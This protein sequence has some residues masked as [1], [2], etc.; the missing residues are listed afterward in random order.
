MNELTHSNDVFFIHSDTQQFA[1]HTFNTPNFMR[2]GDPR[3]VKHTKAWL[4]FSL[5][6]TS[7]ISGEGEKDRI[8]L[9][10]VIHQ[11]FEKAKRE[12]EG[13]LAVKYD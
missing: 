7:L 10:Q 4:D 8:A 12:I 6:H 5:K 13:L 11:K 2:T 9:L 1:F 3:F